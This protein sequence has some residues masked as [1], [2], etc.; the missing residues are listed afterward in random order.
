MIEVRQLSSLEARHHLSQLA[1]ILVDCVE[2]GASVSFMSP[3]TQSDAEAFFENVIAAVHRK[4]RILIAAFHDDKPVGTVQ[5]IIATPPNQPHRGEIAKML[6]HRST[7]GQ[8]IAVQLLQHAE[9]AARE[10]GKTLLNMDTVTGGVAERIY[11]RCGW[12]KA[13][14]IPNYALMPDGTPCDTTIFWKDLS[15]SDE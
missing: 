6:V 11:Q 4:E 9:Q 15:I 10:A 5:V 14:V 8:G 7:R 13:G 1:A 2:G 12:T 3:F